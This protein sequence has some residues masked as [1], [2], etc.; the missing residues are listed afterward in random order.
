MSHRGPDNLS[1]YSNGFIHLDHAR[2]SIIDLSE[3]SNQPLWDIKS[4]ACIVFNGEIYNYRELRQML[5]KMV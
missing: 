1:L 5:E 2:L 3:S 4:R